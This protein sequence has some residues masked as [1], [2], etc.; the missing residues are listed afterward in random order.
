MCEYKLPIIWAKFGSERLS[1][2]DIVKI[3]WGS[4]FRLTLY[5]IVN[6]IHVLNY[7]V[8]DVVILLIL[9]DLK[10]RK[11]TKQQLRIILKIR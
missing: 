2:Q 8:L 1:D 10:T 11:S 7:Y 9:Q 4:L 3:F 5:S 6:M